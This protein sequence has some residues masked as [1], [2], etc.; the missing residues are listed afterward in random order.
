MALSRLGV[1]P[2]AGKAE[3]F[4]GIL[5]ELMPTLD[6]GTFL[7]HAANRLFMSC[8]RTVVITT[9]EKI[10]EHARELNYY[11]F[12]AVQSGKSDIWS[13]IKTS[14]EFEADYYLFTMPDTLMPADSFKG[15]AG[16]DFEMGMHLTDK[17]ERYGVLR[18]GRIVNKQAGD[19]GMAWGV[20][21]WSRSVAEYWLSHTIDNYTDA[22]NMAI[23]K[24]GVKTWSLDW[25]Y[26][27]AS[28]FDYVEYIRRG[29]K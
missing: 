10:A 13:A 4:G 11:A 27:N 21:S 3:R 6:G 12:Y 20:L 8:S 14:L 18:D 26:D 5:K 23:S 1:I 29:I 24:F 25:Y 17:P 22:I 9:T 28:M 7:S 16:S 2:A 15:C 19:A